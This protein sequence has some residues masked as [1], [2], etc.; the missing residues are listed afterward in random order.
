MLCSR[1]YQVYAFADLKE[2]MMSEPTKQ[3]PEKMSFFAT[4]GAIFWSFIGLRLSLI[5]I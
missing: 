3:Q 2:K 5:H 4:L 1:P